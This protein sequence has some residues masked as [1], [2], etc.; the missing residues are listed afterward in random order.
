MS[1]FENGDLKSYFVAKFF[2]DLFINW[3]DFSAL[4][5][6]FSDVSVISVVKS[7]RIG[8][9]STI[10]ILVQMRKTL[11]MVLKI[12]LLTLCLHQSF[13]EKFK[14]QRDIDPRQNDLVTLDYHE[15]DEERAAK[16]DNYSL[17]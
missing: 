6:C 4:G 10:L 13:A 15:E 12:F 16:S 5:G 17:H 11:I 3:N 9:R 14:S 8:K 1:L 7:Q 2:K